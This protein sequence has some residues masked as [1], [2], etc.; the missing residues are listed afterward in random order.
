[1]ATSICSLN[2][3]CARS[4]RSTSCRVIAAWTEAS[5]IT[6]ERPTKLLM[7]TAG[8]PSTAASIVI[9]CESETISRAKSSRS[10]SSQGAKRARVSR[11]GRITLDFPERVF[12]VQPIVRHIQVYGAT[13]REVHVLSIA[14]DSG[15]S[16]EV[17]LSP[18]EMPRALAAFE[19]WSG[20]HA[21]QR[22]VLSV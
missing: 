18:A 11:L 10:W 2:C 22:N 16:I 13:V 19:I 14:V 5:S 6:V 20:N 8:T 12:S 1:M 3:F 21:V 4:E 7:R 17:H 15:D 9:V